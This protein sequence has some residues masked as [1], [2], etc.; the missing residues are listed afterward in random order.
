LTSVDQRAKWCLICDNGY[1]ADA[2]NG[3]RCRVVEVDGV[4]VRVLGG[5]EMDDVDRAMFA[6][7]VR[8][9]ERRMAAEQDGGVMNFEY[10]VF[11]RG[12][13]VPMSRDML[14]AAGVIE[15]TETERAELERQA[16]ES[17]QRAAKREA[18]LAEARRELAAI[19][20]PL[21]R[22]VLDLHA[23]DERH[24]C[25]GCDFGG[26]EAEPPDWPCSTIETIA[27]HYGIALQP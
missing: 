4:P 9:A 17:K 6:E 16:V 15:P 23:E 11:K 10:G 13:V 21:T 8:A 24:E 12:A 1:M 25:G 7:V 19:A 5:R 2:E 20:D 3:E 18:C 22:A 27:A 14:L 26:Y